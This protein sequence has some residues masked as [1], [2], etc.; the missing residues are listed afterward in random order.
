MARRL[1]SDRA[2]AG[3]FCGLRPFPLPHSFSSRVRGTLPDKIPIWPYVHILTYILK[4]YFF[5]KTITSKALSNPFFI[6]IL[7]WWDNAML[8]GPGLFE[9]R[10]LQTECLGP[11]YQL[12]S[13]F[14]KEAN[15]LTLNLYTKTPRLL[16]FFFK[17]GTKMCPSSS[18]KQVWWYKTV[19]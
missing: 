14:T 2:L 16:C 18:L 7:F 8:F 6:N 5:L 9:T 10:V 3:E 19:V 1:H 15:K 12:V 4:G 17:P 13:R 11:L